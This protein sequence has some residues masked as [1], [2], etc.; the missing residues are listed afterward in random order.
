V[1][2]LEPIYFACDACGG[3][4]R[5]LD[6]SG[7]TFGGFTQW[8]DGVIEG[9]ML[10]RPT[11]RCGRCPHCNKLVWVPRL[12]RLYTPDDR[13][14]RVVRITAIGA[15]RIAVLN[16]VRRATGLGLHAAHEALARVPVVVHVAEPSA[17]AA[18]LAAAGATA[19]GLDRSVP[20]LVQTT[21][22]EI[23]ELADASR[24]SPDELDIRFAAWRIDNDRFRDGMT[25]MPYRDRVP[26]ARANLERMLELLSADDLLAVEILRQLERYDDARERL[27]AFRDHSLAK[28]F[29]RLLDARVAEIV[30]L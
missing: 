29:E 15:Q 18:E 1:T 20:L 22:E 21:A 25:W 17:V 9:P 2:P 12:H 27:A 10:A 28:Q 11:R 14:D 19:S 3:P 5:W 7:N 26:S 4:I 6:R 8:S 16:I 30:A 24:G 23:V 13:D